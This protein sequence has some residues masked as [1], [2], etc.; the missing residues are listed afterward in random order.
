[1][2]IH[3]STSLR[4]KRLSS[5]GLFMSISLNSTRPKDLAKILV[6]ELVDEEIWVYL[7]KFLN[8]A[9]PNQA[10][11]SQT[12]RANDAWLGVGFGSIST[13]H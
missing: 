11:M 10:I 3:Y 4:E 13:H 9:D 6:M 12:F 8:Q 1:M 2:P 5:L 7:S